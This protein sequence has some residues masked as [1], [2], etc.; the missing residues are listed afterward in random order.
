MV[1]C[2][3]EGGIDAS[4]NASD[5]NYG[6]RIPSYCLCFKFILVLGLHLIGGNIRS[7][8][9]GKDKEGMETT[10]SFVGTEGKRKMKL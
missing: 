3:A 4:S 8:E 6:V 7:A 2:S 9:R 1:M 5:C 10:A